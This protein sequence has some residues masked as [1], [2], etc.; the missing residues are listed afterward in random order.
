MR[1]SEYIVKEIHPSTATKAEIVD[2][3]KNGKKTKD[4]CNYR[5]SNS[6]SC[7][8]DCTHYNNPTQPQSSCDIVA[9]I[10]DGDS[11]C[12]FFKEG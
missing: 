3:L 7:C 12:D 8:V 5:P 6:P 10:V 11:M 1:A 4:A 9:G 2:L